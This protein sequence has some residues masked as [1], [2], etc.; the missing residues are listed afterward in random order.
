MQTLLA[1]QLIYVLFSLQGVLAVYIDMCG[2]K[3]DKATELA[4]AWLMCTWV[5]F[6]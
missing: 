4:V 1:I 6:V 3:V 5:A 2:K